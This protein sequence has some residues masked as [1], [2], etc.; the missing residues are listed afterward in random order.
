VTYSSFLCHFL[1]PPL[2]ILALLSAR[3]IFRDRPL[4]TELQG[5]PAWLALGGH[6]VV[7]LLYT[8]PWDNYLVATRVWWY[9]PSRVVGLTLGWV[10]LEEYAFFVLQTLLTGSWLI[11]LAHRM[12]ASKSKITNSIQFRLRILTGVSLVW[13]VSMGV[14]LLI[15]WDRATYLSL[16]FVWALLPIMIQLV[17][18][19][20]ILWNHRRLVAAAVLIPTIYLVVVDSGAV[21]AGTWVFNPQQS[22]GFLLGGVLPI[23]EFFFFLLTNSL[24]GFGMVLVMAT[25]SQQR[26]R[27][28][29]RGAPLTS[30]SD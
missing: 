18:G 23:E 30:T 7:A 1:F 27:A 8:T 19:A 12:P 3:D 9:E 6:I 20:D 14:L 25:E 28:L 13:L 21:S 4:A 10:P 11:W 22:S 26:V 17:F 29:L 5:R 24:I 15:R 2:A 16:E